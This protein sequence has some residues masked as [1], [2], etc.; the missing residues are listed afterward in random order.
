[1]RVMP[2]YE[3]VCRTNEHRFEIFH[4]DQESL[5]LCCPQCGSEEIERLFSVFGFSS[6]G[7]FVSSSEGEGCRSCSTKNCST[8]G[9]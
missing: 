1:M 3:Y 4:R 5:K 6:G 7:I 9:R 8:C 2:I